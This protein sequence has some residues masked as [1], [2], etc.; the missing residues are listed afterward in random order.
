MLLVLCIM[1]CDG[2]YRALE[3][4]DEKLKKSNLSKS[5]FDKDVFIPELYITS[6]TDTILSSGERVKVKYYSLDN[7]STTTQSKNSNKHIIT[8]H[9]REF[10]SEI[11]V[12]SN[13]KLL[14][15]DRLNKTDFIEF[16]NLKFWNNA[17]LQYVWLDD[18]E[19]STNNISL[20]CSFLEPGTN[21][22][23]S[24]KVYFNNQ[25]IRKIKRIETS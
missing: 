22:Y 8:T 23:K 5:F 19:S 18:L 14:F 2:K 6:V 24:Y 20:N 4:P 13:N 21:A 12:F 15:K 17:I 16:S 9:Y 25:G 1:S 7:Q 3:T 11:Q 10:E